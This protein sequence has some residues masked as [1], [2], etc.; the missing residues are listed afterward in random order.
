MDIY[1]YLYN[2][3]LFKLL[4]IKNNAANIIETIIKDHEVYIVTANTSYNCG[5]CD[6][7][8]DFI[9]KF[10]PFFPIK[11]VI[12]INNKSL[13]NLDILIDDG[14]HNLENFKGIKVVFD[15]PWNQDY[16]FPIKYDCRITSWDNNILSII[17]IIKNGK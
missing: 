16:S 2:E 1:K 11:N 14:L 7:K 5:V 9:K 10:L 17:N 4:S 12:F 8:I 6:D 13:L 15:R 3:K